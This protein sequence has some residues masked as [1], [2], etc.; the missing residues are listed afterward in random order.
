MGVACGFSCCHFLLAE[1]HFHATAGGGHL[2]TPRGK[3]ALLTNA[4]LYLSIADKG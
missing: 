4:A 2:P 1:P 3:N